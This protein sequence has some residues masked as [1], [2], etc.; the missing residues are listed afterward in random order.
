MERDAGA[1][2]SVEG[3]ETK[4]VGITSGTIATRGMESTTGTVSTGVIWLVLEGVKDGISLMAR[5]DEDGTSWEST[6]GKTEG[7]RESG[8]KPQVGKDEVLRYLN[9]EKKNRLK[10]WKKKLFHAKSH[11]WKQI[12]SWKLN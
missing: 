12:F 9:E 10:K 1:T 6:D 8:V 4:E 2:S 5:K 11:P 7:N 3:V